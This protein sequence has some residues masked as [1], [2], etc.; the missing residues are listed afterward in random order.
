MRPVSF[1]AII[2]CLTRLDQISPNEFQF[3]PKMAGRVNLPPPPPPCGFSK[4]V[5]YKERVKP[6][7]FVTCS[8]ILRY[9]FPEIFIELSQVVQKI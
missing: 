5:S 1:I 7:F 3:N 9:I 6:W 2:F 4:N 8:I